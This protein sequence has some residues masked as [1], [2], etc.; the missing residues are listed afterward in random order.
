MP[1]AMPDRNEVLS[2]DIQAVRGP[3]V[4]A[5]LSGWASYLPPPFCPD[6]EPPAPDDL[7][8]PSAL[9]TVSGEPSA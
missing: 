3:Q 4:A 7:P 2:E 8:C 1:K 9:S 6:D 5:G